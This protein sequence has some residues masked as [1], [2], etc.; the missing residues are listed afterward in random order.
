MGY[1]VI[2]YWG[3]NSRQAQ[4]PHPSKTPSK[5]FDTDTASDCQNCSCSRVGN[6]S[7][8]LWGLGTK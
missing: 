2:T 6:L 5:W 3:L 7:P 8:A 4:S 1:K